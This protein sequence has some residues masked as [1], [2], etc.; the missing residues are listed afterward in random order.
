MT[1]NRI[2]QLISTKK[3]P[4]TTQKRKPFRPTVQEVETFYDIINE[5]IFDS[6]L[7]RPLISL[8]NLRKTWGWCLAGDSLVNGTY[9]EIKLHN[10]WYTPEWCMNILAHEMCH[11]WQYDIHRWLEPSTEMDHGE[12]FSRWI[13]KFA[14][15]GL[16]L[17]TIYHHT[18]WFECQ[19]FSKC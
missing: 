19:D 4:I 6:I 11:Q 10:K 7:V 17:K 18:T 3:P 1:C 12:T 2:Q 13:P 14:S 15:H 5:D 9:C 16:H 8:V